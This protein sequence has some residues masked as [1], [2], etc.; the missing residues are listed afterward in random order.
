MSLR[1]TQNRLQIGCVRTAELEVNFISYKS[2]AFFTSG[3][4]AFIIY[5][6]MMQQPL[7]RTY[8]NSTHTS[9]GISRPPQISRSFSSPSKPSL[10]LH[11]SESSQPSYLYMSAS[12]SLQSPQ[13]QLSPSSSI[14][15]SMGESP[16][17]GFSMR[18]PQKNPS[19][20]D[21]QSPISTEQPPSPP[22]S[23]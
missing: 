6:G 9:P 8:A 1:H 15:H 19:I 22:S 17:A 5:T 14:G 4:Y 13:D 18:F 2:H 7:Q 21:P 16:E 10:C 12:Q 3:A 11:P 23:A 20:S